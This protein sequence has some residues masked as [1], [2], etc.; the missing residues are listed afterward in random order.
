MNKPD[1]WC[2]A[3]YACATCQRRHGR[4]CTLVACI[5]NAETCKFYLKDRGTIRNTALLLV[6]IP[7]S[8]GKMVRELTTL[9]RRGRRPPTLRRPG[10]IIQPVRPTP[11]PPDRE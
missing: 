5:A 7:V 9:I 6:T 2:G 4:K 11:P 3:E 1:K 10:V 8:I